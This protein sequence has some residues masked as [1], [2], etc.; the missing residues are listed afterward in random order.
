MADRLLQN[1]QVPVTVAM[2]PLPNQDAGKGKGT[3]TA[4][5]AE[6]MGKQVRC[7]EHTFASAGL[8]QPY[9]CQVHMHIKSAVQGFSCALQSQVPAVLYKAQVCRTI[10]AER[11]S[12]PSVLQMLAQHLTYS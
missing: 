4:A 7:Q 1:E 12:I 2:Q 5:A 11:A 10:S 9:C 3:G 8:W 6:H